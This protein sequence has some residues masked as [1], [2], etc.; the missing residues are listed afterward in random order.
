MQAISGTFK[1]QMN[2]PARAP[3][4]LASKDQEAAKETAIRTALPFPSL[5]MLIHT[6][7]TGTALTGT[8]SAQTCTLHMLPS[9][10]T[11]TQ[12]SHFRSRSNT[13][14]QP[15]SL[16]QCI[17]LPSSQTRCSHDTESGVQC[18]T[19]IIVGC[20]GEASTSGRGAQ[21]TEQCTERS[22]SRRGAL[23]GAVA[24]AALIVRCSRT[25]LDDA[26]T[27]LG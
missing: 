12:P 18:R 25:A 22:V 11:F 15:Q 21:N 26:N 9:R 6:A 19:S 4:K 7:G 24:G 14:T 27:C 1:L 16:C 13:S 2:S 17:R 8:M 5:A 20:S 10:S 3:A 23:V